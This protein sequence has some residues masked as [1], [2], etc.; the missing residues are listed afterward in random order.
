VA[1]TRTSRITDYEDRV[2]SPLLGD[3]ATAA[4]LTRPD[5][6][7]LPPR[8]ELVGAMTDIAH[9]P[10]INF[11]HEWRR[12]VLA[13]TTQGGEIRDSERFCFWI[14]GDVVYKHAP[15]IMADTTCRALESFGICRCEP[16]F[17]VPHQA[18]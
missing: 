1:A 12:N 10:Q 11:G 5:N 7:Q 18:G 4:L 9:V 13:P 2:S 14:D 6:P 15:Q 3:Y 8:F 17:I 16:D